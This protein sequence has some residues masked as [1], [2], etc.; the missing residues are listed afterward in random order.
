MG[1]Q[2][3]FVPFLLT[4]LLLWGLFQLVQALPLNMGWLSLAHEGAEAATWF[5]WYNEWENPPEQ[6]M[7]GLTLHYLAQDREGQAQ[8]AWLASGGTAVSALDV[9]ETYWRT[10]RLQQAYD[11]YT[12]ATSLN[13]A[14]CAQSDLRQVVNGRFE[15]PWQAENLPPSWG[16]F[17]QG[18]PQ[19]FGSVRAW[20][21][22]GETAMEGQRSISLQVPPL[23]ADLVLVSKPIYLQPN[24]CV[25]VSAWGMR[26]TNTLSLQL[27]LQFKTPSGEHLS[28]GQ[29]AIAQN[30]NVWERL[31]IQQNA[32]DLA[33]WFIVRLR[34]L[35]NTDNTP[36]HGVFDDVVIAWDCK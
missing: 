1:E 8:Q 28:Y 14:M 10:G 12:L 5:E 21:M 19:D 22:P 26:Q 3:P 35:S 13:C 24:E 7:R 15:Q 9:A 32:P 16:A 30:V 34:V 29:A 11:W 25:H 36:A 27:E 4:G 2:R 23:P 17:N 31:Q 20:I 18:D 6:A 33:G